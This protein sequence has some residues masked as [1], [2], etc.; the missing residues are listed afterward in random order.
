VAFT[1]EDFE[2]LVRSL[3]QRSDWRDRLRQLL[4]CPELLGRSAPVRDLVG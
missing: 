3:D 2:D 1:V 4:E